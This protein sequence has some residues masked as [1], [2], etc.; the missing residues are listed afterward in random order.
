MWPPLGRLADLHQLHA[1]GLGR[2]RVEIGF[3]LPIVDQLII[4]A[5]VMSKRRIRGGDM[6]RVSG[7]RSPKQ[8]ARDYNRRQNSV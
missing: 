1:V 3:E 8:R 2:K 4:V 7:C 6:V 5:D